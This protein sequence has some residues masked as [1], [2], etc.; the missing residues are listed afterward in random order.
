MIRDGGMDFSRFEIVA[1]VD[2]AE[3]PVGRMREIKPDLKI[4]SDFEQ[5]LKE[6]PSDVVFILTP[7]VIHYEQTKAALLAGRHVY[8]EKPFTQNHRHA[9]ELAELAEKLGLKLMVGQNMRYVPLIRRLRQEVQSGA[10]GKVAYINLSSNRIV[11][12]QSKLPQHPHVWLFDNAVHDWDQILAI[13]QKRPTRIYS[14]EFDT[15]WSELQQGAAHSV[16]EFED[17]LHAVTQGSFIAKDTRFQLR[18]DTEKGTILANSYDDYEFI[19]PEHQF[20]Q[21]VT[22]EPLAV[23]AA[24]HTTGLFADYVEKDIEPECTAR[25]NLRTMQMICAAIKSSLTCQPVDIPEAADEPID[26]E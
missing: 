19:S 18:M 16:I 6:V 20:V 4:M 9:I 2:P 23:C 11:P 21:K 24:T 3:L 17:G 22:M 26:F 25:K 5:T 15:P 7:S 1:G 14:R 8:C 10:L 13:T 12:A